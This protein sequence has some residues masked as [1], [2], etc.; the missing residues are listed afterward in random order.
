MKIICMYPFINEEYSADSPLTS[1]RSTD[2]ISCNGTHILCAIVTYLIRISV[3]RNHKFIK[4]I[5]KF[6]N[7]KRWSF[8]EWSVGGV[9]NKKFTEFLFRPKAVPVI[10]SR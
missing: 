7:S 3:G 8:N 2:A 10:T 1:I 9:S 6:G 5:Q 4:K